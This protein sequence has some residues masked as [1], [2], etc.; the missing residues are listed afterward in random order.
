MQ[1]NPEAPAQPR[2]R[3]WTMREN[4]R[5]GT[6][7]MLLGG[8]GNVMEKTVPRILGQAF[9]GLIAEVGSLEGR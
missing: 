6:G 9:D 5:F 4:G 1:H 2:S 3:E 8:Q 7:C